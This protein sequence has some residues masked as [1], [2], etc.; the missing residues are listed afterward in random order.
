MFRLL[1]ANLGYARDID[2]SIGHHVRRWHHHVY[3][4]RA[5]QMRGLSHVRDVMEKHEPDL[6]CFV[7]IDQGSITNGFFDQMAELWDERHHSYSVDNKYAEGARHGRL[8][9]SR[10]KSN[11]FIA[12]SPVSFTKRYFTHGAK[13]L[14]YDIVV[15][16]VHVFL[17]HCSLKAAVRREQF[18]ELRG[19]IDA[20]DA[21]AVIIGDFNLLKGMGELQGLLND[22]LLVPAFDDQL[23]T[24]R[25]GP[26]RAC[27]DQC[28]VSP[29]LKRYCRAEVIDQPFSDHQMLLVDL[30]AG[31]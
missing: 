4:P 18:A 26:W 24:F 11:G 20:L 2:G 3:T 21:P 1:Y 19:W 27:L 13:R 6:S 10:G 5:A 23:P 16:G 28:L 29:D 9:I 25:F 14:V 8:S 12:S 22:R 15:E 31:R 7:E 17:V 30:K